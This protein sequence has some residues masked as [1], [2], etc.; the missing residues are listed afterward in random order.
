MDEVKNN[1]KSPYLFAHIKT[2]SLFNATV[3]VI[4]IQAITYKR[5]DLPPH[6]L[7]HFQ[8]VTYMYKEFSNNKER[9]AN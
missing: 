7:A 6:Y 3:E 5:R 2:G 9:I 4:A 8:K 1:S